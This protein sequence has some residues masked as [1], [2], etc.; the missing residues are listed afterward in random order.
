MKYRIVKKGDVYNP[1]CK[2]L[3]FWYKVK[4]YSESV[5]WMSKD[6]ACRIILDWE[7]QDKFSALQEI[8]CKPEDLCRED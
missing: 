1:Q 3:I 8:V 4:D 7:R 6:E 2:R 5:R